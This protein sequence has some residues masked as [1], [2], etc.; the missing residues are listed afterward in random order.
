VNEAR[1]LVY[2]VEEWGKSRGEYSKLTLTEKATICKYASD[3][4]VASAIR[5]FK[6]K[7]LIRKVA[8][9]I[10]KMPTLKI[11]KRNF[12]KPNLVRKLL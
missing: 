3:H 12:K 10:G 8:L 9:G 1:L 7:N 11:I 5:E 4:G 6:E 2:L